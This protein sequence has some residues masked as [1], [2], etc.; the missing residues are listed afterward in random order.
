MRDEGERRIKRAWSDRQSGSEGI[1][2]PEF[3]HVLEFG[4]PFLEPKGAVD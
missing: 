2:E 3:D 1:R 4:V